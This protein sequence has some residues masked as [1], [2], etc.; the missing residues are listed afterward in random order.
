MK[1]V[2]AYVGWAYCVEIVAEMAFLWASAKMEITAIKLKNYF[3]VHIWI[4]E[5][6]VIHVNL[7]CWS[8]VFPPTK[9]R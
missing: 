4:L 5:E 2:Y 7:W 6:R 9:T 3:S 1:P 8:E